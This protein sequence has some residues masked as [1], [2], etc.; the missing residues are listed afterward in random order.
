MALYRCCFLDR[1][2]TVAALEEIE[3]D[4]LT[5]AREQAWAMLT[6]RPH[7]AAIEVWLNSR[8]VYQVRRDRAA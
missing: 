1:D 3:A 5:E 8:C 2:D 6:G 4:T 7:H